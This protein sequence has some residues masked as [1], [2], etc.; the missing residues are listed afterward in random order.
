M[1]LAREYAPSTC[2]SFCYFCTKTSFGY[3]LKLP[4]LGNSSENSKDMFPCKKKKKNNIEM[5]SLFGAVAY[6]KICAYFCSLVL[7]YFTARSRNT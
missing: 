2:S 3:S 4:R 1:A 7:A 5:F 6:A